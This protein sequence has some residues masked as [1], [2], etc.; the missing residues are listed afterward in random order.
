[1]FVGGG[2]FDPPK[3]RLPEDS[4]WIFSGHIWSDIFPLEPLWDD[5]EQYQNLI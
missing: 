5:L 2:F 4:P 3:T 1:M